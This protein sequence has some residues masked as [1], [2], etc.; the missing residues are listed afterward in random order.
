MIQAQ[1]PNPLLYIVGTHKDQL[2]KESK[3]LLTLGNIGRSISASNTIKNAST[4]RIYWIDY[5]SGSKS[6]EA[7]LKDG[8]MNCAMSA[9]IIG[10]KIPF[11]YVFFEELLKDYSKTIALP[12][13]NQRTLLRLGEAVGFRTVQEA[14]NCTRVLHSYGSIMYF[15]EI[16]ELRNIVVLDPLWYRFP[17]FAIEM[18]PLNC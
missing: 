1:V 16:P 7:T 5:A 11:A 18:F 14:T 4:T 17:S 3:P 2:P 8:I 12:V 9:D 6:D 15:D 10:K 13:I